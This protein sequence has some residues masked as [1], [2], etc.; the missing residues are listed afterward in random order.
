[1]TDDVNMNEPSV[2]SMIEQHLLRVTPKR[3]PVE[4]RSVIL[5]S[6]QSELRSAR[7]DRR[8]ARVA[9][10]LMCLAVGLNGFFGW[11]GYQQRRLAEL[12]RPTPQAIV[13]VTEM[14]ALVT[15]EETGRWFEERLLALRPFRP[16]TDAHAAMQRMVDEILQ[17]WDLTEKDG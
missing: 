4:M 5:A 8:L 3:A 10:V 7:W 2:A 11:R 17:T 16:R 15:D 6:M 13:E 9:A 1:M 14:I 12:Q